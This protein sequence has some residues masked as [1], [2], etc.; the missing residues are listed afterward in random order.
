[1]S[2][3]YTKR[4]DNSQSPPGEGSIKKRRKGAARLSC[5]ECRRQ[6][7][8]TTAFEII[9]FLEFFKVEA[10]VRSQYTLWQLPKTGL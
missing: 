4:M 7:T 8:Q 2:S 3:S 1:M 6:A 10:E 9:L 5:A